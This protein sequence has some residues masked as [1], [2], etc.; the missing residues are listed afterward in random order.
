M[1]ISCVRHIAVTRFRYDN[2]RRVSETKTQTFFFLKIYTWID[3]INIITRIGTRVLRLIRTFIK[4]H[5][6]VGRETGGRFDAGINVEFG[7]GSIENLRHA[8]SDRRK[9]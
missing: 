4:R 7:R 5:V 9:P 2:M 6:S 8:F 3:K 1:T